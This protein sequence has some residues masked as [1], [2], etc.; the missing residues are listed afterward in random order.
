M[1]DEQLI[2]VNNHHNDGSIYGEHHL[3]IVSY[4]PIRYQI[5][6]KSKNAYGL[7]VRICILSICPR[8]EKIDFNILTKRIETKIFDLL[9]KYATVKVLDFLVCL[10]KD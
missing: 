3:N 4:R 1:I 5:A 10:N 8:V 9:F 6:Y 7:I 2:V